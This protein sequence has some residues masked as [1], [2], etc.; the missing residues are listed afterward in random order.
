M[1]SMKF[2]IFHG[3]FGNPEDNWFPWLKNKLQSIN[4]K[5]FVPQFPVDNWDEVTKN[6][7][8]VF[9]K[10]QNLNNWL[11]TYK[12]EIF[13]K[14]NKGEKPFFIGH[15]IAAVFILHLVLQFNIKLKQAIFVAPFLE[16]LNESWQ[17]DL[18]NKT[19]YKNDFDF[20]KLKLL[21][22][23]SDVIYSDNDPYVNQKYSIDFANKLNSEKILIKGAGHFNNEVNMF[24]FP[25]VYQLCEKR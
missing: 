4:Q 22:P 20:E 3:A 25:L 8:N 11:K 7:Q 24:S 14:I 21:I 16:K 17:I 1:N 19:F 10:N 5:V 23:H 12:N 15:S 6:G 2:V 18:V 13:P 9:P